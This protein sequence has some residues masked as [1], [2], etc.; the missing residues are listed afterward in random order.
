MSQRRAV[1]IGVPSLLIK[2]QNITDKLNCGIM[3]YRQ[4]VN[5]LVPRLVPRLVS[6]Q[7]DSASLTFQII[8]LRNPYHI[9]HILYSSCTYRKK[10]HRRIRKVLCCK[11]MEN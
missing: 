4:V 3:E 1:S 5:P 11:L 6:L 8:A 10:L 2:I 9:Y 7:L